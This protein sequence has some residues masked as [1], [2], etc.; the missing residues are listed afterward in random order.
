MLPRKN[1]LIR[2]PVSNIDCLVVTVSAANPK[3]D[4]GMTDMLLYLARK[5]DIEPLL[6]INKADE[7]AA[8]AE[9]IRAQYAQA[10]PVF[11]VSARTGEGLAPLREALKHTAH[12]FGGQ[13]GVG[14]ST[15][16]NALYGTSLTTGSLSE[17]IERG[18]HTTRKC[19]LLEIG[20]NLVLDT[21]GFSL[22]EMDA[23][24]PLE[25]PKRYPE[26]APYA[27]KCRFEP[28][29]HDKEPGCAVRAAV[30]AGAIDSER[31]ARYQAL[32]EEMSHKW[33]DRYG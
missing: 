25:V 26:F 29:A 9:A 18:R 12:A 19:E 31:Y 7:D 27:G 28:C 22:L 16:I 23:E 11:V 20:D 3:A 1:A 14:K 30:A 32:F 33:R 21:P 10:C 2:P 15:L 13:S 24:E 4:L 5:A 6:V 8:E 17:K